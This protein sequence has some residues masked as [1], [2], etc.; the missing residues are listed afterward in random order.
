MDSLRG[1]IEAYR[2]K[3][4]SIVEYDSLSLPAGNALHFE[5]QKDGYTAE[6]LLR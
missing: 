6:D 4:V 3:Q 5:S 1:E 2:K